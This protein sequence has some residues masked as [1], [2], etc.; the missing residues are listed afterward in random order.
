MHEFFSDIFKTVSTISVPDVIDI[1]CVSILFYFLYKFVRDRRSG[2][3]AVGV[4]SLIAV[5]F[6][7]DFFNMY[8]IQF[9]LQNVFQLGLIVLAIVFQPELRSAL[10]KIGGQPLKGLKSISD[11]R[12]KPIEKMIDS[13]SAAAADMSRTKTGALIVLERLTKLGDLI[14]TGTVIDAEPGEFLIK[15]I[16]FNKAP[17][18]DGA[19]IVRDARLHAAGC[20]LPLSSNEDIIK[21]LGTRHRAAIGVSENSDAVVI[22][23]SEETGVISIAVEGVLYRGYT[24]ETLASELKKY[25]VPETYPSQGKIKKIYKVKTLLKG[26]KSSSGKEKKDN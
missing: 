5:K 9:I 10:E 24:R 21:D 4:I 14:L 26:D 1:A 25:M 23:V 8:V 16:F 17:L 20:L 3:L 2:K 7:S 15:N 12:T 19:L 11:T 22:V 6:I 18:H 13:V